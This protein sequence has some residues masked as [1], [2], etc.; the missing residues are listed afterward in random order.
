MK[1]WRAREN[2]G[3]KGSALFFFFFTEEVISC[4]ALEGSG[5]LKD[6]C[7]LFV[8]HVK[9]TY[10]LFLSI[11]FPFSVVYFKVMKPTVYSLVFFTFFF[12]STFILP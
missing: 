4:H 1:Q 8:P 6:S 10:A 5:S 9:Y 11:F 12:S 7:V 3:E 2:G